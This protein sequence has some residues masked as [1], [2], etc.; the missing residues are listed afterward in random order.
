MRITAFAAAIAALTLASCGKADR[1]PKSPPGDSTAAN[2]PLANAG[3]S[4]TQR[5]DNLLGTQNVTCS[6]PISLEDPSLLPVTERDALPK[7]KFKLSQMQL[8][9]VYQSTNDS[10]V[11]SAKE[12]DRF[13]V[14]LDCNGVYDLK[15]ES[16]GEVSGEFKVSDSVDLLGTMQSENQR[17]LEVK[18]EN[19]KLALARSYLSLAPPEKQQLGHMPLERTQ[20]GEDSY[21]TARAYAVSQSTIELRIKLEYPADRHGKRAIGFTRAVYDKEP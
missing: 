9:M 21:F 8:Y 3:G 14:T 19:G 2:T 20:V 5:S 17:V 7:G 10:F 6:N 1:I 15:N 18:F 4:A 11:A 13:T 12:S 16:T